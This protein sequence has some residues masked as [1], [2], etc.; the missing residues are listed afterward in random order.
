M[1][2]SQARA[3][4]KSAAA[5]KKAGSDFSSARG[6]EERHSSLPVTGRGSKRGRDTEIE[7]VGD[8]YFVHD[9]STCPDLDSDTSDFGWPEDSDNAITP[10]LGSD[11]EA[12]FA[13]FDGSGDGPPR[14]SARQPKPKIVFEQTPTPKPKPLSKQ[15]QKTGKS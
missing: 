15:K 11:S 1:D 2:D 6:S 14:R 10:E 13:C 3:A 7:K 4:P 9:S 5:K 12:V 8:F